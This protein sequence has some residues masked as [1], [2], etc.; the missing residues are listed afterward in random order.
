M[1]LTLL[2]ATRQALLSYDQLWV[3]YLGL[4]GTIAFAQLKAYF[5]ERAVLSR[6]D[7]N[8]LAQALNERFLDMGMGMPV[9]YV[10]P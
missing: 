10:E 2:Q 4:G 8:L 5:E 6:T 3:R 9:C 1:Q 7:V